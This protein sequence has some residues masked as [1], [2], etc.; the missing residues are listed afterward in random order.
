MGSVIP[1]ISPNGVSGVVVI[2]E[3]HLSVHTWPEAKYL[4]LDIYTCGAESMPEAAVS[5][6]L[7]KVQRHTHISELTR[8]SMMTAIVSTTTR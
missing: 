5:H 4:A 3:S 6:V 8:A 2:S 7:E 1:Q